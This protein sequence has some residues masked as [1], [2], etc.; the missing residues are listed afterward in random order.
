MLVSP[1]PTTPT[2]IA[3][4]ADRDRASEGTD[5]VR[6]RAWWL[7]LV[8]MA[9]LTAAYVCGHF[10]HEHWMNSGPVY[11]LIGGSAIVAL[12][13]GAKINAGTTRRLPWSLLAVGQAL[14]VAGDALAYNYERIFHEQLPFPSIA[15]PLY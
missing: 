12:I 4:Q 7:Y 13:V 9:T 5:R 2:D 8:G 15:D 10:F 14:F 6:T 1:T 11:N 3:S